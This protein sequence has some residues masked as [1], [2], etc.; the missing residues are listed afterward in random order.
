[1]ADFIQ[2]DED[3]ETTVNQILKTDQPELDNLVEINEIET[4][5]DELTDL[6]ENNLNYAEN[7]ETKKIELEDANKTNC[8]ALTIKEEHKLVAVKN[9]FLHSLKVTW[10]VVV[11]T[12]ALHILKIF[13]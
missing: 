2:N 12:I 4:S 10:K 1:M 13:F 6:D 11:S 5:S 8:L 3:N 9:V 7:F